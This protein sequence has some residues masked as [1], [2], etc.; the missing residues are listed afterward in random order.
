VYGYQAALRERSAAVLA[1]KVAKA[2]NI[3][4]VANI[5]GITPGILGPAISGSGVKFETSRG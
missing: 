2:A 4:K 3:A 5:L 1:V